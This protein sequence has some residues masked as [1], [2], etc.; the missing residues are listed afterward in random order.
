[1]AGSFVHHLVIG[2]LELMLRTR[3]YLAA[4]LVLAFVLFASEV[5]LT[6]IA[7]PV[8]WLLSPIRALAVPAA[9]GCFAAFFILRELNR[10]SENQSDKT[11]ESCR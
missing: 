3:A 4:G 6:N 2:S 11:S 9:A 1:M 10:R 5:L 8:Q 7:A